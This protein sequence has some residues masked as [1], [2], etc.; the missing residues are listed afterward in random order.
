MVRVNRKVKTGWHQS[1]VIGK[2]IKGKVTIFLIGRVERAW[3]TLCDERSITP[4]VEPS[5]VSI[6]DVT[7]EGFE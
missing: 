4:P 7:M 1:K 5:R 2:R 3:H 6:R